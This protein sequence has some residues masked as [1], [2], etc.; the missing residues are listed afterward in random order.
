MSDIALFGWLIGILLFLGLLTWWGLHKPKKQR[1]FED[2]LQ[3]H[4]DG[5][6]K[7]AQNKL[8]ELRDER[9]GKP[10]YPGNW[11]EVSA[12]RGSVDD[13]RRV[14]SVVGIPGMFT[15]GGI[16]ALAGTDLVI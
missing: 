2:W 16:E 3:E 9:R 1:Q 4:Y 13:S 10:Q 14:R 11:R 7:E 8:I 6:Q 12:G 15:I 5:L